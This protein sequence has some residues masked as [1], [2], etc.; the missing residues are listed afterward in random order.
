MLQLLRAYDLLFCR[1][2]G[3]TGNPCSNFLVLTFRSLLHSGVGLKLRFQCREK[4]QGLPQSVSFELGF[5]V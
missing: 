2:W 1:V 4:N 5:R 3:D